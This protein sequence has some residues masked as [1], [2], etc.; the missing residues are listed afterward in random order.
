[1]EVDHAYYDHIVKDPRYKNELFEA[2]FPK[3]ESLKSTSQRT[4]HYWNGVIVPQM[5][6]G[7]RV[8]IAAHGNSLRGI[9]KHLQSKYIK[10]GG[11][12]RYF[13]I[14]SIPYIQFDC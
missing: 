14:F 3:T 5:K 10:Q 6:Q 13:L 8:I 2:E 4:L 12:Y 11:W 1:M 9:I 7:K